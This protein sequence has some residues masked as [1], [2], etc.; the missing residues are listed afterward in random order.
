MSDKQGIIYILDGAGASGFTPYIFLKT[1]REL[2]YELTH[3]PWGTGY[4]RLLS[5]LT[6]RANM[7]TRADELARSMRDYK[8]QNPDRKIHI[9]AKSAGTAVALMALQQLEPDTVESA[10]L[11]APAVSPSFA[12]HNALR[13]VRTEIVSFWSPL[14][15]FWLGFCTS[16]FGT[17]DGV[18]CCSSGLVGFKTPT[19]ATEAYSKLRQIKWEPSMLRF[20]HIGD[21]MGNS[22]PAF[23][24]AY[25]IPII[26]TAGTV[27]VSEDLCENSQR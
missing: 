3:F 4:M 2:P 7:Q 11:L 25:I 13:A 8:V 20:H 27:V 12:L 23:I 19:D 14:D 9:I 17:A 16:I 22:M 6:N 24:R 26:V 21:H 5:D 1:L 10:V 15:L 18:P